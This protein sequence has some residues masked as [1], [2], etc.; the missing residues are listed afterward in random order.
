MP[1]TPNTL[2]N[3]RVHIDLLDSQLVALLAQR[4]ALTRQVGEYKSKIGMPIYVPSREAEL[5]AKRR[6]EA[7]QQ[8]VPPTL[9]EDLLRRIMRESYLTQ[10]KQYLCVNPEIKKVVIIGGAGALGR[11]F[12]D[13][14]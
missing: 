3:L 7:E 1:A 9:V 10:H 14:F 4:A 6:A 12:V 13:M 8:G 2:D 11:I 5:I